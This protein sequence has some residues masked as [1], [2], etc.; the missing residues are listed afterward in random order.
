MG[1]DLGGADDNVTWAGEQRT[2]KIDR[3][4]RHFPTGHSI[5]ETVKVKNG[6]V[7]IVVPDSAAIIVTFN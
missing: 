3:G 5:Q 2:Y 6:Q 7:T 1:L 4:L